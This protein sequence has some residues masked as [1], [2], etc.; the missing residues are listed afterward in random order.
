MYIT[1]LVEFA[2]ACYHTMRE[3]VF[4]IH[5]LIFIT[6][7]TTTLNTNTDDEK[8]YH[9]TVKLLKI[10]RSVLWQAKHRLN[11]INE[12][13]F[14]LGYKEVRDVVNFLSSGFEQETSL[15]NLKDRIF[16]MRI[17]DHLLQIIDDALVTLRDYPIHGQRYF[18]ILL[19][20]YIVEVPYTESEILDA[21]G[22]SRR[23]LYRDKK[24][25]TTLLGSILWGYLLPDIIR[26]LADASDLS[27]EPVEKMALNWHTFATDGGT[28]T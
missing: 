4:P 13:C 3:H 28:F 14:D 1:V 26:S 22:I 2:T 10:Y 6:R 16:S 25:A 20:L 5:E 11:D 21:L 23:T 9:D 19:K 15:T 12:E 8:H 27:T 18:D 24:A 7:R 17:T